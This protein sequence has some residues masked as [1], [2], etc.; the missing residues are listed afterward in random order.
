MVYLR[1][2]NT[3][4]TRSRPGSFSLFRFSKSNASRFYMSQTLAQTYYCNID[5]EPLHRYQPGGYHPLAL[6][7]VL[8]DG[9]YKIVH[10]LGW[11]GYST[12]WAAKD[13]EEDEYVAIKVSVSETWRSRELSVLQAISVLPGRHFESSRLNRMIDYFTLVGP[14]GTHDCLVLELLGPSVADVVESYYRD[15]RLPAKLAKSFANQAL[16]G[17]NVLTLVSRRDGKSLAGNVPS[18]IVRPAQFRKRDI[19][20][21]SPSIKIIDFG[22]A[23]LTTNVPSTLHTPLPIFELVTGQP[24]FDVTMLTP[25]LL[26]QQMM[27]FAT[28]SLPSRW[29]MKWQAMQGNLLCDDH[30]YTLQEWL[31]EVYFDNNKQAEFT[32]EDI[33]KVGKLIGRMLKFEPSFRATASDA[34]SDTWFE[35]G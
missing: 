16:Q 9:R 1:L 5:A 6:G 32:R 23:F 15:D 19:L 22:E 4:F 21:S 11:G 7:D 20:Q 28:D 2:P 18:H 8:K 34:L 27:E 31:E 35:R 25:P 3:P 26:V 30:S 10:K 17:L 14:N 29:Q 12:T 24:P 13:Q 33:A